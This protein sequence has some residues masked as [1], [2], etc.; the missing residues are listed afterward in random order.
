MVEEVIKTSEESNEKYESNSFNDNDNN[1][2]DFHSEEEV[3]PNKKQ[4]EI[5]EEI[6]FEE[7]LICTFDEIK[8]LKKK[9]A[10]LEEI[11]EE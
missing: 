9:N 5:K 2:E 10:L 8:E 6:L 11:L 1:I 4:S 3:D 7:Q